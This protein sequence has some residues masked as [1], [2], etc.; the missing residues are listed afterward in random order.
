MTYNPGLAKVDPHAKKRSK[1]RR[2]KQERSDKHADTETNGKTDG[3]TDGRYQ[4]VKMA[5]ELSTYVCKDA[6]R[7]VRIAVTEFQNC[8]AV[9]RWVPFWCQTTHY[10]PV[11]QYI[12]VKNM[13]YWS[14]LAGSTK[15]C[16]LVGWVI[17]LEKPCR[18]LIF[19]LKKELKSIV[20]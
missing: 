4:V 11:V 17:Y 20:W 2:F 6:V 9:H 5:A 14:L 19:S 7:H 15:I 12:G 18:N 1:A 3:Q 10:R 13:A 8:F 16:V